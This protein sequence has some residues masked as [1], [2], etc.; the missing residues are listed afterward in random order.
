MK[1]D[2]DKKTIFVHKI[3][4]WLNCTLNDLLK[5]INIFN[6]N[7][8]QRF[9]KI[10]N[11]ITHQINKN[12]KQSDYTNVNSKNWTCEIFAC[13]QD[14]EIWLFKLFLW[15]EQTNVK[16]CDDELLSD[17]KKKWN[18]AGSKWC[19]EE[20]SSFDDYFQNDENVDKMIY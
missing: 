14:F 8:N 16:T 1:N 17:V 6:T 18:L 5:L 4:E 7:S 15:N 9:E 3:H 19:D 10:E 2:V 12:K 20:L 11:E 13:L